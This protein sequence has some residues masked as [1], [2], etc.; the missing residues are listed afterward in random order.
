MG[1][2]TRRTGSFRRIRRMVRSSYLDTPEMVQLGLACS[3]ASSSICEPMYPKLYIVYDD[4]DRYIARAFRDIEPEGDDADYPIRERYFVET[5]GNYIPESEKVLSTITEIFFPDSRPNAQVT[6]IRKPPPYVKKA[7]KARISTTE[8]IRLSVDSA[9]IDLPTTEESSYSSH[10]MAKSTES[11]QTSLSQPENPIRFV[12][13]LSIDDRAKLFAYLASDLEQKQ[14]QLT[15]QDAEALA[16]FSFDNEAVKAKLEVK[17]AGTS[18]S[19][20]GKKVNRRARKKTPGKRDPFLIE[21]GKRLD[22]ARVEAGLNKTELA[23]LAG[24][25]RT[26]ISAYIHGR[27]EPEL[28]N[29][30]KLA[31]T[32]GL[33][34]DW[35]WEP[36]AEKHGVSL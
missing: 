16:A 29:V 15:S 27:R 10:E 19:Q 23:E 5:L 25:E 2:F 33:N 12:S 8:T 31:E 21:F 3:P 26:N 34:R 24:I 11:E 20:R 30:E 7:W 4:S 32:L 6:E 18:K 9:I 36:L 13:R 14:V 22:E 35:L 28:K 17:L 1:H